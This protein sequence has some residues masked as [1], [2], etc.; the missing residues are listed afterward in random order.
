MMK[1]WKHSCQ[2]NSPLSL[3]F[4]LRLSVSLSFFQVQG[5]LDRTWKFWRINSTQ[6]G[7]DAR[8]SRGFARLEL[9]TSK[10]LGKTISF[11]LD[12]LYK[13]IWYP[14]LSDPTLIF[15]VS[16][17]VCRGILV[18]TWN[19]ENFTHDSRK[20]KFLLE[21][22]FCLNQRCENFVPQPTALQRQGGVHFEETLV[23]GN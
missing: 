1:N 2:S 22:W 18:R 13:E 8:N 19:S 17:S 21:F 5:I 15:S 6:Q 7:P 4:S 3:S 16:L 12:L 9:V 20:P 11:F 14:N 10:S 23:L